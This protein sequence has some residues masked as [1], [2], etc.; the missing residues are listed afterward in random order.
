MFSLIFMSYGARV[1]AHF[2]Q[3]TNS[4]LEQTVRPEIIKKAAQILVEKELFK[5]H[6][7]CYDENWKYAQNEE[8]TSNNSNHDSST[9]SNSTSDYDSTDASETTNEEVDTNQTNVGPGLQDTCLTS[10]NFIEDNEL[11]LENIIHGDMVV[12]PTERKV[13]IL[14]RK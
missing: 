13:Y 10:P 14:W 5:E 7:I 6:E 2:F 8:E 3:Y 1:A 11:H 9:D 12:A 4:Y